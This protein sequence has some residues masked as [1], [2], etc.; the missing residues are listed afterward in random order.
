MTMD[1]RQELPVQ[2]K[3]E[4]ER[5][6]E[7][8]IPARIFVPV[9][10]IYETPDS[11]H[12]ILEMPGVA[13]DKVEVRAEDGVLHVQGRLDLSAYQGLQPLYIEYNVGHYERR[14]Q[15][16]SR[17]DQARIAAELKDG[18]LSLTLPKAEDAKPRVIK[19]T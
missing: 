2:K 10:D 17:I 12:V 6:E 5:K 16:S 14:F 4:H 11:L 18:V 7:A 1:T 9:T 3:R 13:R 15:L 19:V 8:T